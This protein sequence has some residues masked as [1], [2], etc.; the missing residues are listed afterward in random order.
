MEPN[1]APP[2]ILNLKIFPS[3]RR[4]VLSFQKF[5]ALMERWKVPTDYALLVGH[6]GQRSRLTETANG[7]KLGLSDNQ[8]P[9]HYHSSEADFARMVAG[10][11]RRRKRSAPPV[12]SGNAPLDAMGLC[13]LTRAAAT[14]RSLKGAESGVRSRSR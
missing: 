13:D 3:H 8:T 4:K 5:W 14:L 2:Q 11:D 12:P 1:G 9:S 10:T 7:P 6:S